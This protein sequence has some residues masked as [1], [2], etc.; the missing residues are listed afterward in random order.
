[1]KKNI[2]KCK[3]FFEDTDAIQVVY[4][5]NYLRFCDRARTQWMQDLGIAFAQMLDEPVASSFVVA[6]ADVR[7][8]S[9]A[10]LGDELEVLSSVI[11]IKRASLTFL[12]TVMHADRQEPLCEAQIRCAYVSGPTL[13]PTRMPGRY[14]DLF[15]QPN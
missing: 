12:Q 1:M 15:T 7:F 5:A 3:V 10:R 4:H 2:F 8:L 6:R 14:R 9:P 13:K 11:D